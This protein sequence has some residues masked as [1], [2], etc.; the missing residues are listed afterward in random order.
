MGNIIAVSGLKNSGKDL[1]S[2]MIQYCLSVPRCMRFY[3]LYKLL[4]TFIIPKYEITGFASSLKEALSILINV[5]TEKFNNRE[6]KESWYIK[7]HDIHV[8]SFPDKNLVITD[9]KL[10]RLIKSN[11]L[12]LVSNYYITIRQLLQIFGTEIIRKYFGDSFWV[13]RTLLNSNDIIISDMRFI[14]EYT[15]VKNNNGI[16]IYVDRHQNPGLHRSESEVIELYKG[17][18]FDYIIDN[19]KDL[20]YLFNQ[21]S[22]ISNKL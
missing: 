5:P 14:V 7:L 18:K 9:K 10:N 4:Y 11:K 6:F 16:T 21:V 8:T 1:V 19:S 2:T 22:H 3:W 13:S 20:K 12:T 17:N 15:Y